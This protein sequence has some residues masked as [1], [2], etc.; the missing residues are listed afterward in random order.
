MREGTLFEFA[1]PEEIIAAAEALRAMGHTH[2][3]AYTP[4]AIPEL[5][6][7]LGIRR[8]RIPRAVLVAATFGAALAFGILWFTNAVDYPLDVGG[9]PLDSVPAHIPIMFETTVLFGS[10]AAFLLVLLASGL[11]RLYHPIFEV[12]G[13]ESASVDRFWLGM[14]E[15]S[16]LDE[17]VRARMTELGARAIRAIRATGDG[18]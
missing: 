16:P 10:L 2:L 8:T 17:A 13:I 12:D 7:K 4:Y 18:R 1:S 3:E 9:R 14:D 11:P 15:A 6:E 5:E